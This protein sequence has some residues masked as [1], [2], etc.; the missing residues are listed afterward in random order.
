MVIAEIHQTAAARILQRCD[1]LAAISSLPDG[2]LRA[3]LTPEHQRANDTVAQWMQ[4]V[5]MTTRVDAVGNIWGR[6]EAQ[7]ANAP[8]LI[9]GSHLDT[10]PY[11]GRYDG[12]LGVLLAIE[13]VAGLHQDSQRLPFAIEV[14]GFGDE[15]GTR[16]GSTLIGS[17]AVAGQWDKDW[18]ELID[19]N[20]LTL[21]SALRAF[22][23]DP[24][25]CAEAAA[26]PSQVLGY[27]EVHIEQGPVLEAEDL[28]VGVVTGIAGA[29]RSHIRTTGQAG[30]SGTTPM[31]LRKD[32]LAGAAEIIVAVEQI[33]KKYGGDV[34]A[35]VGQV[36]A[37]PGAVNVIAGDA[38]I[39]LDVRS[40]ND[41]LRDQVLGAIND[42]AEAIVARRGLTLAWNHTHRAPAVLCDTHFQSL[43]AK[44]IDSATQSA[45]TTKFLPS[46]AG[47]DAMAMADL[48]PVA[49]L[50][51]RSPGGL[52]HHPDEGVI[53]EDVAVAV[54]VMNQAL[55]LFAEQ[56]SHHDK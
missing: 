5:G 46:G 8:A 26:S 18:L 25:G 54:S 35:T 40:Q 31:Y 12:I 1:E 56:Y 3:Y 20:E 33:A 2:I 7:T 21:A 55:T 37:R 16:F 44:A 51:V 27:W 32:S 34:V 43:L 42:A 29:R 19:E 36:F 6:Y 50:F 38:I 52:S 17:K 9:L 39:S 10:V 23:L 13:L 15:E 24:D 14:V 41:V 30:H 48:C 53:P 47:H 22:G 28:P 49:M 11:A 4:Q 45:L